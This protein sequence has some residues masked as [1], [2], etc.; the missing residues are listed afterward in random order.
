[1]SNL[2]IA[3]KGQTNYQTDGVGEGE[4]YYDFWSQVGN[5]QNMTSF[6]FFSFINMSHLFLFLF[7]LFH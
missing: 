6:F 7:V 1:M 4:K 5:N 2:L 3:T